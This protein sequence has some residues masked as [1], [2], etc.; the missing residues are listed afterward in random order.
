MMQKSMRMRRSDE[1]AGKIRKIRQV[2]A[3]EAD[4]M[5]QSATNPS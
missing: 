1:I 5:R 2:I 4:E 3:K